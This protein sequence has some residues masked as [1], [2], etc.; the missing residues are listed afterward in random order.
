[1]QRRGKG[2]FLGQVSDT[3]RASRNLLQRDRLL[4]EWIK[5]DASAR[6]M[7]LLEVDGSE[8]IDAVAARVAAH[9]GDLGG[10]AF[11][12]GNPRPV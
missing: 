10:R 12:G 2:R 11:S 3:G 7:T 9:F 1:M 8:T 4:T 5:A 6:H